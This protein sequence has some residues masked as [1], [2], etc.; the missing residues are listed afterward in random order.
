MI[1][2]GI[3]CFVFKSQ[4]IFDG[5]YI[6]VSTVAARII[7]AL[8]NYIFNYK[9]VFRSEGGVARTL[10]RYILLAIVQMSL[11]AFLVNELYPL[12]GGYEIFIKIPVDVTL[13]FLSY[14]I[15]REF[16]YSKKA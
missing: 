11:S 8:Y 2:F 13:F 5:S 16:V 6:V 14:V 10:P 1:L 9:L 3:F 15:Q 12:V 7:S 4:G